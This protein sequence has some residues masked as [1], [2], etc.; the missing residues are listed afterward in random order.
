M[1]IVVENYYLASSPNMETKKLGNFGERLACEYLVSKGYKIIGRNHR[2]TF[3]E[4]DIIAQKKWR[5]FAK[6]D[7]SIHFVEVKTLSVDDNFHPEDHFNYAKQNKYKKLVEIWLEENKLS[8]NYP[9]QVD[10]VAVSVSNND[11]LPAQAENIRHFE[12]VVEG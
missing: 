1:K 5:L 2:V 4:I 10:L 7:N 3:G 11:Q 12:N 9:C 6:N 8:Q